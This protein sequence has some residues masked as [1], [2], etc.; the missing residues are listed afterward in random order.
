MIV[1][2][3]I[4]K[5]KHK[6]LFWFSLFFSIFLI[7]ILIWIVGIPPHWPLFNK[8]T[9]NGC[10]MFLPL[11]LF[12]L[13]VIWLASLAMAATFNPS[14]KSWERRR[15]R[16]PFVLIS[17]LIAWLCILG[18]SMHIALI[19]L[20]G[21]AILLAWMGVYHVLFTSTERRMKRLIEDGDNEQ[22]YSEE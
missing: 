21:S 5:P 7:S 4:K 6:A 11:W 10:L 12:I 3:V 1:H 18:F 17:F 20:I 9:F 19:G 15:K 14:K 22:G 2:Q 16:R 8:D 13:F